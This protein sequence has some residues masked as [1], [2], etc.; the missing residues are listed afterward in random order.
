MKHLTGHL[1]RNG[2]S[3]IRNVGHSPVLSVQPPSWKAPR[4][5]AQSP[6]FTEEGT[7]VGREKRR[8]RRPWTPRRPRPSPRPLAGAHSCRRARRCTL[9][10]RGPQA[11]RGPG[12]A[13]PPAARPRHPLPAARPRPG[14]PGLRGSEA[15]GLRGS[16]APG[17]GL[18]R[19]WQL[20][21]AASA[22][23]QLFTLPKVPTPNVSPST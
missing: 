19:G 1:A 15:P 8:G 22:R 6:G 5:T 2:N 17:L 13:T 12:G 21:A 3:T 11:P 18:P 9:P 23:T 10:S 7:E 14:A 4:P 20:G 16:G